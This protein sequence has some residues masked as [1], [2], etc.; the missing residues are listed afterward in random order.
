MA[1]KISIA[2]D[3]PAAAGKSTVAKIVAEKLSYVYIDTGAMY[4]AFTLKALEEKIELEDEEALLS[5]LKRTKIDLLPG[6]KGQIVLLDGRDVTAL[7]RNG[8]VTNSVSIVAKHPLVRKEMV[9]RQQ[10]LASGG[11]VV[12]DGRDIGTHVLPNAEL[13]IFLLASVEERALRRHKENVE[14][15]FPSDLEKL[16]EEI[17]LRDKLDSER[18]TAPLKKAADAVEL[19]TTS[20]SINEVVEKILSLAYERIG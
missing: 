10:Q 14:N 18:E 16:K 5:S 2:I 13:K 6:G 1:K 15:G 3:G 19:D 11:G 4:R 7:I 20:L 9:T 8:E 12:M 17:A